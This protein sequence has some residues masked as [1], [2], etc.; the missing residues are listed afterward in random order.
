ML[1]EVATAELAINGRIGSAVL[2]SAAEKQQ[3][4]H[5]S[6]FD[7]TQIFHAVGSSR[8]NC[9]DELADELAISARPTSKRY[10]ALELV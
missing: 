9:A 2:I 8:L 1:K 6:I 3:S 10:L 4:N 5:P 7:G